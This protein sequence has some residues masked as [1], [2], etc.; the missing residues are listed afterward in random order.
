MKKSLSLV[1]MEVFAGLVALAFLTYLLAT[2]ERMDFQ[3]PL[4]TFPQTSPLLAQDL[5]NPANQRQ[6]EQGGN[7]APW[8]D[9]QR[10][11]ALRWQSVGGQTHGLV[12][13]GLTTQA[14]FEV[15]AKSMDAS[16]QTEEVEKMQE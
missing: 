9:R 15:L 12:L 1:R 4:D 3:S 14:R 16:E 8:W 2:S 11:P 10:R 13:R 7:S 5:S 6:V